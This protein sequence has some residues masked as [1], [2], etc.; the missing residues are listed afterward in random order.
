MHSLLLLVCARL[1]TPYGWC[2]LQ[3]NA[4]TYTCQECCFTLFKDVLDASGTILVAFA[5]RLVDEDNGD[6]PST[7]NHAVL[8]DMLTL[9]AAALYAVYTVLLKVTMP[10]DCESDMMAFFGYLGAINA[11]LFAPVLLIM[12]LAGSFN[13]LAI[14]RATYSVALLK[15]VMCSHPLFL[16]FVPGDICLFRTFRSSD[17]NAAPHL[18]PATSRVSSCVLIDLGPKSSFCCAGLFD[19]TLSDYLWSKAVLLI[20][21]TLSLIHI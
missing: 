16:R 21:P 17:W 15:G 2:G 1:P 19:N 14:S 4:P 5:D 8:G 10:G 11:V 7:L 9:A 12:Q 20:G 3:A 6:H 13:V 18:L